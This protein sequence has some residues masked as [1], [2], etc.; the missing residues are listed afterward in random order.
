MLRLNDMPVANMIKQVTAGLL[1]SLFLLNP[2]LA[3]I[4][5]PV[6]TPHNH[7][8]N[9][10]PVPNSQQSLC[11]SETESSYGPF[12]DVVF[13]RRTAE[14][15]LTFLNSHSGS[16]SVFAG[17]V[18]STRGRYMTLGWAE[19]GHPGF[20]FYETAAFLQSGEGAPTVGGFGELFMDGFRSFT[21]DGEVSY[22]V[23]VEDEGQCPKGSK[24]IKTKP[25]HVTSNPDG[26]ETDCVK[27]LK[28][29][30]TSYAD[31]CVPIP[32]SKQAVCFEKNTSP[33]GPFDEVAF[34]RQSANG[35]QHFLS[36]NTGGVATFGGVG[37]STQGK[38]MWVSWADEGH[39]FFRFYHTAEFLKQGEQ[40]RIIGSFEDMGFEGIKAFT[41]SGIVS[42]YVSEEEDG[43]CPKGAI[44]MNKKPG[45]P[46]PNEW[47]PGCYKKI[48]LMPDKTAS[49]TSYHIAR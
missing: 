30:P 1:T 16:V 6:P 27:F 21:D 48:Q 34:F 22:Y 28:L 43:V 36:L 19:E 4:N 41:D 31:N 26:E 40:A 10:V 45:K 33:E 2:S 44:A 5:I 20:I 11:Y 35:E 3:E 29:K 14:G 13:Y 18:F 24:A 42:Y 8:L 32:N 39:G 25:A 38:L 23:P 9:C 17:V 7:A 49:T 46:K 37:F 47:V 15:D 12:S